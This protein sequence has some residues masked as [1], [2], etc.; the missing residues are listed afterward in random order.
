MASKCIYPNSLDQGLKV[1]TTMASTTASL[2]ALDANRGVNLP[3]HFIRASKCISQYARLCP[4]CAIPMSLDDSLRVYLWVYLMVSFMHTTNCSYAPPAAIA[5][6]PWVDRLL[7]RY[8]DENTRRIHDYLKIVTRKVL[9]I[10]SRH[11]SSVPIGDFVFP[12]LLYC[13]SRCSQTCRWRSQ[14]CWRRCQV[15]PVM[16]LALPGMSRL[17]TVTLK[18]P[19]NALLLSDSVL[20]LLFLSL[21]STFSQTLQTASSDKII[22][23]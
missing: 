15:L 5:D 8:I 2:N 1:R 16:S 12:T 4:T 6:I 11:T 9:A 3:V 14:V 20:K 23:R 22:C 10:I 19:S 7:Y 17:L 21:H 18:A 13:D